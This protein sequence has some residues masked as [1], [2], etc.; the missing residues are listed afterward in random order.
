MLRRSV[1]FSAAAVGN[2]PVRA[3]V[4]RVRVMVVGVRVLLLRRRR[5]GARQR[6]VVVVLLLHHRVGMMVLLL[7]LRMMVM[8]MLMV[9]TVRRAPAAA[10]FERR[11][12][13]HPPLARPLSKKLMIASVLCCLFS[14]WG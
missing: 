4:V 3:A 10:S 12:V 6:R 1:G 11:G 13:L 9:A 5:V 7:L 8:L 2:H 14:F